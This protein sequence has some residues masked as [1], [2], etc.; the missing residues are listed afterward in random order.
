M[1]HVP[2]DHRNTAQTLHDAAMI[3]GDGCF[4]KQANPHPQIGRFLVRRRADE[5][6]GID[7]RTTQH[8]VDGDAR[9]PAAR[10]AISKLSAPRRVNTRVSPPLASLVVLILSI[11]ARV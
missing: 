9:P 8:S 7:P 2:I 1:M 11:G 10:F 4:A 3:G 5:G 6:I